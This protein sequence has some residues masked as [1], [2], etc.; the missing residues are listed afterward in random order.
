MAIA[1][2]LISHAQAAPPIANA[3]PDITVADYDGNNSVTVKL[4]GFASTDADAD[5][6]S[7]VWTWAGGSAGTV[8][9]EV[10]FRFFVAI[11]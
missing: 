6:E 3:G 5:L 1:A 2:A 4:N 9:S 8:I 7:Y 11:A 10:V